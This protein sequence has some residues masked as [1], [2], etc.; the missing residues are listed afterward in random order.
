MD[1]IDGPEVNTRESRPLRGSSRT[2]RKPRPGSG[3][4]ML[5]RS[6]G[7]PTSDSPPPTR[8]GDRPVADRDPQATAAVRAAL[9]DLAEDTSLSD[10]AELHARAAR[11]RARIEE[12]AYYRA[13]RRGFAPGGEELDWLEAEAE[14]DRYGDE[15]YAGGQAGSPAG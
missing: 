9:V 12:A 6:S 14:I 5:G 8:G 7:T 3:N 15:D 4:R 10:E 1:K 11:R 13:E 2:P